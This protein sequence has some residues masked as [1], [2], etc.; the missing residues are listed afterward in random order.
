[1][2]LLSYLALV[3]TLGVLA[4]WLAWR[5]R[6][7][8]I[9][10]LLVFG[11]A[12]GQWISPDALLAQLVGAEGTEEEAAIGPLLLFPLVSLSVAIILFEGGLSLRLREL[13]EA[14]RPTFRLVTA[15]TVITMILASFAAHWILGFAWRLSFLLGAILTV[16]GP[17]VIGP[18]L[19]QI[20][21]SRRI[22][23]TLK[24]EG[25]VIDPVGAVLAVLVFEEL[26][27]NTDGF[28]AGLALQLLAKMVVVGCGL[29][30]AGGVFLA[31]AFRRFWVPDQLHGIVALAVALGLFALSDS[32]AE[33]AGL[34][35][36][37]VLGIWLANQKQTEIEHIIEFKEHLRTLLIGCLFIVLGSRLNPA[38]VLAFGVPGLAF[39]VV[40]ILVVRPVSVL[41]SLWGTQ[42]DWRE[43]TF[44]ASV[45][46]RGIVAAAVSSV[47]A[48]KLGHGEAS[49]VLADADQLVTVTF[50]VIIGTVTVYGLSAG[51]LA[52]LLH[53][54]Q[55]NPQGV[56]IA[57]ADP[58]ARAIAKALHDQKV[59]VLMVDTN[60]NK[61]SA[62][63]MDGIPADCVNIL[64]DH[65]RDEL[66]LSG[67]GR[68]LAM[69]PNDEV[70]SLAVR[71]FRPVFGRAG[72]YQ[73]DYAQ[74]ATS[75]RRSLSH[76]LS[77]RTLFAEELTFRELE[78]QFA[79]G[80][81]LKTTKL[82]DEYQLDDFRELYGDSA[83]ILFAIQEDGKVVV[84]T[85]DMPITPMPGQT[86]IT[87]VGPSAIREGRVAAS[88][89]TPSSET[90]SSE[91][92]ADAEDASR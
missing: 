9:L 16:T 64:S 44:L 17:T 32:V 39:L 46:P 6:L 37:T 89:E 43:R 88:S 24:W 59:P 30:I 38:D 45:A 72:V 69:T 22:A 26:L 80:A 63:K 71:E 54:A 56:L 75:R 57:G 31:Q 34:I 5:S 61:V 81:R 27:V 7:P 3:P 23:S 35:T 86:L 65:A 2:D 87:W 82:S 68:L 36:V 14:G 21:P 8:A 58:C 62:A 74:A 19:Q 55:P 50:L 91:K 41:L 83:Y 33:E 20:R 10:L 15:G 49:V 12:L 90:P 11:I 51:L 78:K 48:L 28:Q 85:A 76:S 40:I 70:N 47:F 29:G 25:I 4:Q 53:L 79:A 60:Y 67:M 52:R 13:R 84:N 92:P 1:M 18:L 42:L 73:F 77:G 66:D